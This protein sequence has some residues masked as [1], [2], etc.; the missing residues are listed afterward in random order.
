MYTDLWL[1]LQEKSNPRG[2]P[3]LTAL[4]YSF[5]PAAARWWLAGAEPVI[6]FDPVWQALRDCSRGGTL[7][8]T[9]LGYG[10]ETLIEDVKL[11]VDQ[12]DAWRDRHPGLVAP[13]RLPTFSGGRLPL[14][15]KFGLKEAINQLGGQWENFFRYIHA[16]AFLIRDWEVAMRLL[17]P[18][19]FNLVRLTVT[20]AGV[21]R[22]AYLH[23]WFWLV[24]IK[25]STRR[26][27]GLMVANGEGDLLRSSLVRRSQ[28]AGEKPWPTP[29]EVWSLRQED[30][31]S[32]VVNFPIRDEELSEVVLNLAHTA[33]QGPH[34][35][36]PALQGSRRCR[37]CSFQAQCFTEAGE[38]TAIALR[39]T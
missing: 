9:L 38:L 34:V 22:P 2:H 35:P 29:P 6:P 17:V 39:A 15:K 7:L 3:I 24:E 30:S 14:S 12:V 27:L 19:A 26:I 1:A 33:Q 18:P 13:E 10:F 20:L 16:W 31:A 5:C 23:C 25:R 11:Y 21:R 8:E 28:P 37:S 4:L 32:Q 36:L